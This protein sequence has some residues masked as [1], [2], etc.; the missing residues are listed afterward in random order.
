MILMSDE[1]ERVPHSLQHRSLRRRATEQPN[2]PSHAKETRSSKGT[3]R[4]SATS[5]LTISDGF[6][7]DW[8]TST[9]QLN[10]DPSICDYSVFYIMR[11]RLPPEYLERGALDRCQPKP[12]RTASIYWCFAS[13][14]GVRRL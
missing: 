10:Y 5:I 9:F 3:P 2:V 8:T 12:G 11:E 1:E 13:D 7:I 4:D 6:K 14:Q